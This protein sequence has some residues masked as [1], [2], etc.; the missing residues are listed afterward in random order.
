[1]KKTFSKG[2]YEGE[3]K[4]GNYHGQ[5][6]YTWKVGDEYKGEW[7]DGKRTGLGTY[8]WKSGAKYKGEFKDGKKHGKEKRY[9]QS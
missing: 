8:T 7:K 3:L 5:G 1:M 2:E 9:I 6:T 4:D